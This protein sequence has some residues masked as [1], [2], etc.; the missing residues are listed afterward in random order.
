MR[1][2]RICKEG[3][4]TMK[5]VSVSHIGIDVSKDYWDV[6]LDGEDQVRRYETT[7]EGLESLLGY[8]ATLR[9]VRVCLEATGGWEGEL[10]DALCDHAIPVA[11]VNPR[12]IRDFARAMNQL[13][14]TDAIDARVISRFS[15]MMN[16]TPHEK[17]SENQEKLRA[18]RTRRNQVVD[19]LTQEK[20]RLATQRDPEIRQLIQ[21]AIEWYHQQ[22]KEIDQQLE[23]RIEADASL[24]QK[25]EVLTSVPGVAM[26]TASALL[27]EM[28][29]L[30][31][32][33][34]REAARL[35]GLA[36]VNRDSGKMRGKRTIGGGRK[37]IRRALYMA[38]L[39]ATRFNPRIRQHYQH[40]LSQG[41]KKIVALTACMRKL[42]LILNSMIKNNTTWNY[43]T[44]N[45]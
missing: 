44:K 24:R 23:E 37:T 3:T 8:L 19:M 40:L 21:H 42:L 12:Q 29:E 26:A 28:P 2:A 4:K 1:Q 10:V 30:G 16:P 33:N 6:A 25:A 20:N 43:S 17:P 39:V 13:A 38:T 32:L 15:A 11:V 41:K 5:K 14:K 27:T 9:K 45:T 18:L 34:R 35:A 7:P 31:K 22:L 36:P